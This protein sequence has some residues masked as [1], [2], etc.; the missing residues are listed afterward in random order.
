[1]LATGRGRTEGG[2][3]FSGSKGARHNKAGAPRKGARFQVL[4][5]LGEGAQWAAYRVQ[6]RADGEILALKALKPAANRHPRLSIALSE[7]AQKWQQLRHPGLVRLHEAG[8]EDG[9]F[10]IAADF[11]AGGSLETRLARGALAPGDALEILRQMCAPLIYLHDQNLAHGDVRPRQILFDERG[12]A[13]LCD[14]GLAQGLANAGLALADFHPD[15]A[16]Y[17]APERSG[18][19][20]LSPGADVYSLGATFYRMLT[21]RVPFQ[22][23]STLDTIARHR[24]ETPL[25]PSQINP[26]LSPALD[27]LALQLLDKNPRNRPSLSQLAHTLDTDA[28]SPAAP[29]KSG[30]VAAAPAPVA[31]RRLPLRRARRSPRTKRP[32]S[33]FPS[34]AR[35]IRCWKKPFRRRPSNPKRAISKPNAKN[36][37]AAN[38]GGFSVR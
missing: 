30:P 21:G 16:L 5:K 9:T 26:R 19:A 31:L 23:S 7:V 20:P 13:H 38:S 32:R 8:K 3:D 11:L 2:K 12:Q 22:G 18:G 25:A 1:M 17:L 36:I 29:A 10:F 4:S 15:A 35:L 6:R 24:S 34:A 37:V 27:A 33:R 14:G 28:S